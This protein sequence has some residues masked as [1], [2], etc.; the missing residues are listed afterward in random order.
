MNTD[1]ID[2]RPHL[3]DKSS[4]KYLLLDSG[5]AVSAIPPDPCDLPDPKMCLKAVNGTR[6]KSYGFKDLDIKIGRKSYKIR[7]VKTDVKYPIL[8]YDFNKKHKMEL[9]W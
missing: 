9:G 1:S 4:G 2:M 5:A 6:L 3:L 7:A 8:G